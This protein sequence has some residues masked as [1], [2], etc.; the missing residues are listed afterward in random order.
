MT[1]TP[2]KIEPPYTG[3]LIDLKAI[4]AGAYVLTAVAFTPVTVAVALHG[5][6]HRAKLEAIL[7]SHVGS[8]DDHDPGRALVPDLRELRAVTQVS[9]SPMPFRQMDWSNPPAKPFPNELRT[10]IQAPS[11]S[12]VTTSSA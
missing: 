10:W 5:S 4:P 12:L 2:E 8:H 11:L 6:D 9:G 3:V 1:D 7:P